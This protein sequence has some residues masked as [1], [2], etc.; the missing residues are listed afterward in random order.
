MK[1]ATAPLGSALPHDIV[2][3]ATAERRATVATS[4]GPVTPPTGRPGDIRR[5]VALAEVGR[6][7]EE[8][9]LTGQVLGLP[10]LSALTTTATAATS[11]SA[12]TTSAVTRG[13]VGTAVAMFALTLLVALL[14][15]PSAETAH[16]VQRR[17]VAEVALGDHHRVAEAVLQG[18]THQ[19]EVGNHL[20]AGLQL[21]R[22]G[23]AVA[24][25]AHLHV[26]RHR[27]E[28][29]RNKYS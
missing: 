3:P 24:F 13:S 12:T 8:E 14:A 21:A 2:A 28:N 5:G 7:L 22:A 29:A 4:T 20:P 19:T 16:A 10:A 26:A 11:V 18:A 25:A 9:Q 17:H 23:H 1:L 27:L 6:L 15:V